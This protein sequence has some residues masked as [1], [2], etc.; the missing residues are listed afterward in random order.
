MYNQSS[1]ATYL[2]S[3]AVS[4]TETLRNAVYQLITYGFGA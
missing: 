4:I 3:V 2:M 1:R